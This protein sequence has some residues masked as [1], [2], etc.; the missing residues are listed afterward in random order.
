MTHWVHILLALLLY[1]GSLEG[2]SK[3]FFTDFL[4]DMPTPGTGGPT[5][6]TTVATNITGLV[7]KT[8]KLTC[9]VKNLGNRTVSWV[10]HR[11]I[12]LLTVGRYTYTSDQRFEAMHSPHAED[13]TLRIRYA[14]RK[15]SGI[16]ECQIS[17]TPPIGHSV[18][19][20]IVEPITEVIGGPELHINKGSTINLTCIV[21][22]APEPPPTVIWSHNREVINFDSPRGGIS[23]VTEKGVVTTSRLLV[24]KAIQQ[25]SGLYT[26]TPSNANPTSVRVHIVDGEHPAAM[27]HGHATP[28]VRPPPA[29]LLL[30]LA[31]LVV[32]LLQEHPSQSP[33]KRKQQQEGEGDGELPLQYKLRQRIHR[34]EWWQSNQLWNE[35]F[36]V[37]QRTEPFTVELSQVVTKGHAQERVA[38]MSRCRYAAEMLL[39]PPLKTQRR[40]WETDT[41][42]VAT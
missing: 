23:L 15:D 17:T 24:Q 16:Y 5:F 35:K 39:L 2:A 33:Q 1:A 3:R 31:F 20:N 37:Y 10:R 6:D 9:R 13:W 40:R 8:V 34:W 38:A 32:L 11:D 4:Q 26:C 14:Q 28:Q 22:F 21:K 7:G 42:S 41:A 36:A 29:T 19:L 18:Y 12:H 30:L 25:D 27:H